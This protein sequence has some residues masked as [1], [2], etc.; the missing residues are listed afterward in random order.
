VQPPTTRPGTLVRC[1]ASSLVAVGLE[2]LLLSILVSGLRMRAVP[3]SA[4]AAG[5]Y[6]AANFVLNR[7]WAFRGHGGRIEG[8]L[9]RHLGVAGVGSGLVI[10]LLW[11]LVDVARMP[12]PIGWAVAG[13]LA[14]V[15]WTY[16]MNR[17]FTFRARPAPL[18]VEA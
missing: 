12:Y 1:G 3:A 9:A 7:R 15:G 6:L 11:I 2:F 18:A 17:F 14:F 10:V 16:P 8:Q 5:A 13:L 4:I